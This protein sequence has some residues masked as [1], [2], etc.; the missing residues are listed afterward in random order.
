[1]IGYPSNRL[2]M[3]LDDSGR[4]PD[5]VRDLD[6]A[7]IRPQDVDVMTGDAGVEPRLCVPG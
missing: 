3:V 7:G 4:V 6:R 2:L 5:A 1:M